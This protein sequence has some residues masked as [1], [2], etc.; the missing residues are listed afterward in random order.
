MK[1]RLLEMFHWAGEPV[2]GE[3]FNLFARD[4]PQA[5]LSRMERGHKRQ[6]LVPAYRLP[7]GPGEG[8]VLAD[9]K[10]LS[11]NTS[12]Y[13]RNPRPQIRAVDRRAAGLTSEYGRK[14]KSVDPVM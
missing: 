9:L 11:C 13:P 14:F 1:L 7:G 10:F 8:A 4:I 2:Q 6:G 12:R 3:V 5:G